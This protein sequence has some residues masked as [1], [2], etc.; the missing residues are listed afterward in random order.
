L[1]A[2]IG[3]VK[4]GFAGSRKASCPGPYYGSEF[5]RRDG[6]EPLIRRPTEKDRVAVADP[7]PAR[8]VDGRINN[9]EKS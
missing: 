5:A 9:G 1:T 8:Y 7:S 4:F 3:L 2:G 6:P